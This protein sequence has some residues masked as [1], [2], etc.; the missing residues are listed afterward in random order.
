METLYGC[1]VLTHVRRKFHQNSKGFLDAHSEHRC[2]RCGIGPCE[3]DFRVYEAAR[4]VIEG[5]EGDV[6]VREPL[7]WGRK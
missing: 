7:V 4:N 5:C 3:G 2:E 1:E 6:R